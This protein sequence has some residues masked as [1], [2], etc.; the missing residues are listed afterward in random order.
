MKTRTR[1]RS[2]SYFG[3]SFITI[4]HLEGKNLFV[5]VGCNLE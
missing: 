4:P 1:V 3:G 2:G 5:Q